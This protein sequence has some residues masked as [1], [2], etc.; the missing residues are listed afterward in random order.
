MTKLFFFKLLKELPHCATSISI[1]SKEDIEM[2]KALPY[3][4][5][6][7]IHKTPARIETLEYV[8]TN[9][10]ECNFI[11]KVTELDNDKVLLQQK[12]TVLYAVYTREW[13]GFTSVFIRNIAT[14][15]VETIKED[16]EQ[17]FKNLH[18]I[19]CEQQNKRDFGVY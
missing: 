16:F 15:E 1:A 11:I 14:L 4:N 10:N 8:I 9:T 17:I 5:L 18:N 2:A 3:A 7:G 13:Y 19:V 12:R 6:Y